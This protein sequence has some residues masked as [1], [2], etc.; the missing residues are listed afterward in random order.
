MRDPDKGLGTSR[1]YL[2]FFLSPYGF[3]HAI[4]LGIAEVAKEVFQARRARLAG[5]EP[6]L[7]SR[8]FPYPLLRAMTNVVH[9]AAGHQPG[10]RGDAPRHARDLRHVHRL[11]RD[12]PPQRTIARGEPR[13]AR[14]RRPR[15]GNAG[16]RG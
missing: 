7:D 6:R 16:A 8:G 2:G 15:A 3:V 10:H 4:V 14:W 13:R 12:R 9:A 5:I 11:R 1:S